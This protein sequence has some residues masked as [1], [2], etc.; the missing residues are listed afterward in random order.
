MKKDLV[1]SSDLVS[2]VFWFRGMFEIRKQIVSYHLK[3]V[4]SDVSLTNDTWGLGPHDSETSIPIFQLE[5]S[6]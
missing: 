2:S 6:L 1:F 4:T 5:W 3:D